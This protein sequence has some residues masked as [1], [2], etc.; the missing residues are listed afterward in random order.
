M[1]SLSRTSSLKRSRLSMLALSLGLIGFALFFV[2]LTH[3]DCLVATGVPCDT[4]PFA[5]SACVALLVM[6]WFGV[7]LVGVGFIV[8]MYLVVQFL[9]RLREYKEN[10]APRPPP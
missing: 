2:S 1:S 3:G 4:T 9:R 7:A 8:A 6:F 10:L 5:N